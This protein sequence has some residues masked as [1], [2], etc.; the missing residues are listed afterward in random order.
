MGKPTLLILAAGMGSRY[1]GLKQIDK[2]GPS[3]ET[4]TDYSI[5]DAIRAG[6]GKV[7]C[8]IRKDIEKDFREFFDKFQDKIQVEY[9]FQELDNL[10]EGFNVPGHRTKPWGT[11][12]AVMMATE[13]IKEPFAVINADD[14]YGR[15]A[16]KIMAGYLSQIKNNNST[17]YCMVGYPLK[18]TLSEFGSVSRGICELDNQGFLKSIV[19]RTKIQK[20]NGKIVFVDE[21]G[22]RE[23][24]RPEE[25]VSMNFFGF[26]PSFFGFLRR[27]F[28]RF[29]SEHVQTPKSEFYI[30][31]VVHQLLKNGEAS[32]KV[33]TT[34]S[35][36]FGVTYRED[37][38]D[39]VEKL[40]KLIDKG[41]YPTNLWGK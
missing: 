15:E 21:Q 5:Y 11:G 28:V 41:E 20:D 22:E 14:F 40:Q 35:T 39:V 27:E 3:G 33:F 30:P 26:S 31:S 12:H 13:V 32:M 37:R 7:V 23:E 17:E 10:P 34:S 1:G 16:Y 2:L 24:L 6:F 19:E 4:I 29:L 38:E 25:P 36:W 18:N 8:V 9:V